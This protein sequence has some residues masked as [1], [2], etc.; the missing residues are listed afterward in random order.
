MRPSPVRVPYRLM[1]ASLA[2]LGLLS[3]PSYA[4]ATP[5]SISAAAAAP[6]PRLV[7]ALTQDVDPDARA[8][9]TPQQVA[10]QVAAARQLQA[11]IAAGNRELAQARS[12]LDS[13]A[14]RSSAL[15]AEL[16]A[17]RAAEA[18]ARAEEA[19]QQAELTRLTTAAAKAKDDV[20][21][22]AYQA[23]VNGSTTLSDLSAVVELAAQGESGPSAAVLV[24]VLAQ[25]RAGDQRTYTQLAQAQQVAVSKAAAARLAREAASQK[26]VEAQARAAQLLAEQ[27]AALEQLQATIAAQKGALATLKGQAATGLTDGARIDV[28]SLR[29]I[30]T[31]P[32]CS[33]DTADYPNGQLPPSSLCPITVAP[34]QSM[35]PAAARALNALAAAYRA[36]FGTNLCVTDTYRSYQEQ[37]DVKARR[38]KWAATPGTSTHG[39]GLAVDLCG[40]IDDFGTRQHAWMVS[41]AGLF[42]FFHPAWAAASGSLP[43][44]WHWEYGGAT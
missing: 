44:P 13:L 4:T 9:L 23:Y 6:T 35:R 21:Q 33:N 16:A 38:G 8:P 24:E 18:A 43:E 32:T 10:S 17:A 19:K 42:G 5:T 3:A 41:H 14:A 7:P 22:M 39:L 31:A 30:T 11:S 1:A 34:G 20:D 28:G 40:G 37:V 26:A 27:Q 12:K 25:D 36:D 2:A 15:M 29:R